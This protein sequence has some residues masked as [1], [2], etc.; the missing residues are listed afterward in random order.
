MKLDMMH[1]LHERNDTT[2]ENSF[3]LKI[4]EKF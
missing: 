3:V 2:Q 4:D 1:D